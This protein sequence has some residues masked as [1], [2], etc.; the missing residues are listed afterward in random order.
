MD[1]IINEV[2]GNYLGSKRRMINEKFYWGDSDLR[3]IRNC[4][5]ALSNVYEHMLDN[6]LTKNVFVVQQLG[7]I[8]NRLGKLVQ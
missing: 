6:G 1:R 2:I 3:T 8:V 4:K 5:R 7:D